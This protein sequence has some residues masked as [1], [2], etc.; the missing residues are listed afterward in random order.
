MSKIVKEIAEL[1]YQ[2]DKLYVKEKD[3][4]IK[5]EIGERFDIMSNL[6]DKAIRT[7]LDENDTVYKKS[8]RKLRKYIREIKKE[9]ELLEKYEKFFSGLSLIGEQMDKLLK[10]P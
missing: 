7:Q 2:L 4:K 1:C 8:L 6:L 5:N 10:N 9:S 3:E